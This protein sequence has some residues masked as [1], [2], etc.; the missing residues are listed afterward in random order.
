MTRHDAVTIDSPEGTD[1]NIDVPFEVAD[2]ARSLMFGD[3]DLEGAAVD[4]DQITLSFTTLEGMDALIGLCLRPSPDV[5]SERIAGESEDGEGV[6]EPW[7]YAIRPNSIFITASSDEPNIVWSSAATFRREDLAE[8]E[9]RIRSRP[10][11]FIVFMDEP[12]Q[13]ERGTSQ[14]W[15]A[16]TKAEALRE[17]VEEL[18]RREFQRAR[19]IRFDPASGAVEEQVLTG[20]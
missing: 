8:V 6:D 9:A 4:D 7:R 2:L 19:V 11:E 5:L 3:F 17:A 1:F 16:K 13:A 20:D 10:V 14:R 15:R 12:R 18:E